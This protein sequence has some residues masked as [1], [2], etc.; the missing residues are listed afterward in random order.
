VLRQRNHGVGALR[1]YQ[2]WILNSVPN[3]NNNMT[4]KESNKGK[5]LHSDPKVQLQ[6]EIGNKGIQEVRID[7]HKV[8][9][10]QA[11]HKENIT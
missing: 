1:P 4:G 5:T 3:P 11:Q 6:E 2:Y 7:K 9:M 10:T 8:P